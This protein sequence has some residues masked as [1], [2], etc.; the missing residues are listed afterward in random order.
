MPVDRSAPS[1]LPEFFDVFVG[2]VAAARGWT[3]EES[4]CDDAGIEVGTGDATGIDAWWRVSDLLRRRMVIRCE[5]AKD[6]VPEQF[7]FIAATALDV[8]NEFPGIDCRVLDVRPTGGTSTFT[9]FDGRQAVGDVLAQSDPETRSIRIGHLAHRSGAVDGTQRAQSRIADGDWANGGQQLVRMAVE[10][11][12]W[13]LGVA[14]LSPTERTAHDRCIAF[15]FGQPSLDALYESPAG[16]GHL[17]REVSAEAAM[18][19][20]VLPQQLFVAG[21]SGAS[22]FAANYVELVSGMAAFRDARPRD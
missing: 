18:G 17:A 10:G 2:G 11:C 5:D 4:G 7:A 13:E 20:E 8:M 15:L 9:T 12:M 22:E 3:F 16:R 6:L 1:D 19:R 14:G 21:R